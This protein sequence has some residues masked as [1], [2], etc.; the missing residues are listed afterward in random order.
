MKTAVLMEER[1]QRPL[2]EVEL[3]ML[4]IHDHPSLFPE[5]FNYFDPK[6]KLDDGFN[7]LAP[8]SFREL[9]LFC[10]TSLESLHLD[11]A[12]SAINS[13]NK[14]ARKER[15]KSFEVLQKRKTSVETTT[16]TCEIIDVSESEKSRQER[17]RSFNK[18]RSKSTTSKPHS[19]DTFEQLLAECEIAYNSLV[20]DTTNKRKERK[21]GVYTRQNS[22]SEDFTRTIGENQKNLQKSKSI[23]EP[24]RRFSTGTQYKRC[25]PSIDETCSEVSFSH[26]ST[27]SNGSTNGSF[28]KNDITVILDECETNGHEDEAKTT[29]MPTRRYSTGMKPKLQRGYSD[30]P[31]PEGRYPFNNFYAMSGVNIGRSFDNPFPEEET[32]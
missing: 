18:Q 26:Q 3:K 8:P 7:G 9:G 27:F 2:S 16:K 17:K 28:K 20:I 21:K 31:V 30:F 22:R 4:D 15:K 25:P 13:E 19:Q 23:P 24:K 32:N 5:K 11:H 29:E 12:Y 1:D 10:R 14:R 6:T